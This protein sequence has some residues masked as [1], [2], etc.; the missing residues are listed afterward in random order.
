MKYFDAMDK[1]IF[2]CGRLRSGFEKNNSINIIRYAYGIGIRRFDIAPCYG[3]G[4]VEKILVDAL[5]SDIE[6]II[7]TTKVGLPRLNSG[8]SLMSAVKYGLRPIFKK[9]PLV[10]NSV[11]NE[12]T[13]APSISNFD[14]GYV[15]NTF[16]DTLNRLNVISVETLL[17]HEPGSVLISDELVNYLLDLKSSGVIKNIGVGTGSEMS[18][19]IH[20]GDVLQFKYSGGSFAELKGCYEYRMHGF[21]RGSIS[22]ELSYQKIIDAF[23]CDVSVVFSTIDINNLISFGDF[24][25]GVKI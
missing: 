5:G 1:V 8:F 7:L 6:N 21:F 13:K 10:F 18:D 16:E 2:G 14:L 4:D 23:R 20:F 17:L 19:I 22:R 3:S 9:Y 15:K 11:R 25:K 12:F 24:I